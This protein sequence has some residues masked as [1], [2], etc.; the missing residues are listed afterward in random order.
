MMSLK[1]DNF[2]FY[3][4]IVTEKKLLSSVYAKIYIIPLHWNTKQ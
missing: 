1:Y 3:W 4:A 2:R